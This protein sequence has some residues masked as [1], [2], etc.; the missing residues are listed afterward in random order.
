MITIK[1]DSELLD[2]SWMG[3]IFALVGGE[4]GDDGHICGAGKRGLFCLPR[5][6]KSKTDSR[7]LPRQSS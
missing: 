7:F 4:L 1:D 5:R 6:D 2:R 3:L